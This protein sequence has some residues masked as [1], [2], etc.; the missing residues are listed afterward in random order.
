M[1]RNR[2]AL[3]RVS[4]PLELVPFDSQAGEYY[5]KIKAKLR[6]AGKMMGESECLIAA[7]ALALNLPIATKHTLEFERLPE[8]ELQNRA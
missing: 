4:V 3:I 6:S 1:E 2:N 8:L 7:Q 5:G